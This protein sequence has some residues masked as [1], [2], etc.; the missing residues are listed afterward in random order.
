MSHFNKVKVLILWTLQF[1]IVLFHCASENSETFG[2]FPKEQNVSTQPS[3]TCLLCCGHVWKVLW[4]SLVLKFWTN[5]VLFDLVGSQ[6]KVRGIAFVPKTHSRYMPLPRDALVQG[7]AGLADGQ[8]LCPR[9]SWWTVP[10][11]KAHS[12]GRSSLRSWPESLSQIPNL[13]LQATFSETSQ[14]GVPARQAWPK[15]AMK[16][17]MVSPE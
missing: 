11:L 13:N 12:S 15:L 3:Q 8:C 5:H 9:L 10:L 6:E 1:P 16:P 2:L 7:L 4:N 17:T 14:A